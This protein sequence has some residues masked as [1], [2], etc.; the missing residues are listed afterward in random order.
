[1]I[2]TF[3]HKG[4]EELYRM[5]TTRR[6]SPVNVRKCIRVLHLLDIAGS[7]EDMNIAGLKFHGLRGIPPRWSVRITGNYRVTFGWSDDGAVAIDF[8]DYH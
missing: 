4:L 1:V 3:R 5:G 8:E 2:A 6:I 7:P